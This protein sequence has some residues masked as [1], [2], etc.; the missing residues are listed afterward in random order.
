MLTIKKLPNKGIWRPMIMVSFSGEFY[1]TQQRTLQG[2][3]LFWKWFEKLI[4]AVITL[5]FSE[6]YKTSKFENRLRA[7][8]RRDAYKG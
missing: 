3:L 1:I 2:K 8:I 4:L 7:G 5:F 6:E